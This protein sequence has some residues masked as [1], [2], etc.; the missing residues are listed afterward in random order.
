V[1]LAAATPEAAVVSLSDNSSAVTVPASVTIPIGATSANF[2][3]TTTSVTASTSAVITA[4]Y[5]PVTQTATLAVTPPAVQTPA[6]P[7][8]LGPASG[9]TAALPVTLD[10]TDVAAAASYRIQIDDSS[11]FSAPRVVDQTV[12]ASQFSVGSL[13]SRQH[14]WRVRSLNAAG[15][16]GAWSSVRSFTPQ[17]APVTPAL[18]AV[19][20]SPA[21][22]VGGAAS[23]GTVTLTA[24]APTG[25]AVV[26]LS[27][28]STAATVPASVT[29]LAGATSA[30]FAVTTSTVTASTPV[31]ITG[32]FD[33][34]T[35]TATLTV[36]PAGAAVTLTVTASGRSGERITSSPAGINV[37][38]GSAGSASF[39]GGTA[40][41]LRVTSGRDAVW[42]GA[43]SSGG[44][45]RE[46]CT[47]TIT[48]NVSVTANV[49]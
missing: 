34:A 24:A 39:P 8:L 17:T 9:A 1:T 27:D 45:K 18:S 26:T 31:T 29:V 16:A 40:I 47:F 36:N 44:S 5:G 15:T 42:S 19:S 38:V 2:T 6:A 49:Q 10:W 21:S 37:T 20:L 12:T 35:R 11:T 46:T 22:V 48:G 30:T 3:V 33:G 13:A 41:T 4:T 25:G 7:S 23:T 14:W 28:T 43:C 32:S